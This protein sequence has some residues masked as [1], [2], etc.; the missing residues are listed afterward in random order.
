MNMV[1][2]NIDFNYL[3]IGFQ[4]TEVGQKLLGI[5]LNRLGEDPT[6]ISRNPDEVIFGTINTVI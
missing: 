1:Y 4:V 3:D 6:P 2:L 5:R